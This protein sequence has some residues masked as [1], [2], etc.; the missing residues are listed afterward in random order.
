[1]ADEIIIDRS[2][3]TNKRV[4]EKYIIEGEPGIHWRWAD[5]E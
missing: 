5:D 3:R 4:A 1:M 2:L